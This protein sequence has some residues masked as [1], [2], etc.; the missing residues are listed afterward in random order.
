[1]HSLDFFDSTISQGTTCCNYK[2]TIYKDG[3]L[4][5]LDRSIVIYFIGR[6]PE[7]VIDTATFTLKL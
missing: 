3:L 7:H 6:I 1:M 4:L 2:V 5:L